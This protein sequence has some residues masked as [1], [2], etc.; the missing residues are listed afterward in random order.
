MVSNVSKQITISV[1]KLV[2]PLTVSK[3][4]CSRNVSKGNV[5]NTKFVSEH[6]QPCNVSQPVNSYN[7][8]NQNVHNVRSI[9]H[10]IKRLNVGKSAY[11]SNVRKSVSC[12]RKSSHKFVFN[13]LI[14][15]VT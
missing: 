2:K 6:I 11:S 3:P 14:M 5:C 13:I 9:R 7:V 1:S 8:R 10:H 15:I 12:H 4:I